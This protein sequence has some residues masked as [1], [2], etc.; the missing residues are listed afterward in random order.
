MNR[1][2]DLEELQERRKVAE[3]ACGPCITRLYQVVHCLPLISPFFHFLSRNLNRR[4]PTWMGWTWVAPPSAWEEGERRRRARGRSTESRIQMFLISILSTLSNTILISLNDIKE[5]FYFL[6]GK[7]NSSHK[8]CG[9][10]VDKCF[11]RL[12]WGQYIPTA[13]V[14]C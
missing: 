12:V 11:K 10:R 1:E 7:R 9:A 6:G 14:H 13:W 8:I 5:L 4:C 2:A 3:A